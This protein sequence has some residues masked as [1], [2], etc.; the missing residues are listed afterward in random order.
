MIMLAS[1]NSK[2]EFDSRFRLPARAGGVTQCT[3]ITVKDPDHI[4]SLANSASALIVDSIEDF[5][6]GGRT[7]SCEN[8]EGHLWVFSSHD[9]WVV[10]W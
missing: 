3:S 7:F 9:P 8:L 1:S 2:G 5:A 4:Y 6:F 10:S